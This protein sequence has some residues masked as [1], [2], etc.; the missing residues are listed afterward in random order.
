[1]ESQLKKDELQ[2]FNGKDGKKS[3]VSYQGKVYDVT[4]SRLWKNGKHVNRHEAGMDLTEAMDVA[5]HS[6]DVLERFE[7]VDTIEGFRLKQERGRKAVIKKLYQMFHPHPMLIHFPMGLLGFTVIM[8]LIFLFTK[9]TSFEK[10][11]FYSL[12]TAVVFMLPTMFSGILSWWVNYEFAI[13]KIFMYKLWFSIILFI[14]GC[15]EI[16]IRFAVPDISGGIAGINIFYNFMLFANI[17]VLAVI[18]FNGG[19]L[20]WG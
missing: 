3:Y 5:P 20:T 1:M 9:D 7:H 12:I 10:A 11:S 2:H 18:G 15:V 8:Q 6:M 14:M 16:S 19:K 13:T 17:P 4:N